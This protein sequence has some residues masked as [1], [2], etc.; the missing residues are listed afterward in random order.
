MILF[1]ADGD[2]L[3][4]RWVEEDG[5]RCEEF[6][7]FRSRTLVHSAAEEVTAMLHE[8]QATLSVAPL[9]PAT[10]SLDLHVGGIPVSWG[11]PYGGST[12]F[13]R[14]RTSL[15]RA[16]AVYNPSPVPPCPLTFGSVVPVTDSTDMHRVELRWGDYRVRSQGLTQDEARLEAETIR[17]QLR[18]E[19]LRPVIGS[20]LQGRLYS[21]ELSGLKAISFPRVLLEA[22]PL[23]RAVEVARSLSGFV[24]W[25]AERG[26]PNRYEREDVTVP[27]PLTVSY[28]EGSQ[29][30]RVGR[31]RYERL[32]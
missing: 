15:A 17:N 30:A 5:T 8:G 11:N 13:E 2:R 21:I 27:V 9:T 1:E 7:H 23:S 22:Y 12:R 29:Y 3:F 20:G 10:S 4:L 16:L 31:S 24:Q 19:E 32:E 28:L 18:S 26:G 25:Y 6:F 14:I